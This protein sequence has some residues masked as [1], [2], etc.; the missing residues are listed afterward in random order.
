MRVYQ[1]KIDIIY[2]GPPIAH[3]IGGVSEDHEIHLGNW[4][5]GKVELHMVANKKNHSRKYFQAIV[6]QKL[7]KCEVQ[8][9]NQG[10]NEGNLDD[11][12]V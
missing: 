2:E 9:C 12:I 10:Q 5:H 1:A 11:F 6:V 7:T 4:H 8:Y 3:D